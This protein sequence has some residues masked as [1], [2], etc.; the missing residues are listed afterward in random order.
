MKVVAL[1]GGVGGAKLADGLA[2]CLAPQELTLVVNTGDDFLHFGLKI[3]PDLDTVCYT[4]AGLAN[5]ETGWGRAG[6]TW[7]TLRALEALGAPT[8]FQLGDQ[9]LATHLE[10]TRR[11]AEGETLSEVTRFFCQQWGIRHRVLPMSDQPVRTIV[12]TDIGDLPF[13]EYFV[14]YRFEPSVR[15]FRFE[16]IAQATAAPGVLE[17]LAD[18]DVVIFCPSNPWVSIDPILAVPGVREALLR[19]RVVAVSPIVGG[20][21]LKGP[22]AK[23]FAEIGI[24]PSA[25]A[26]ALHYGSLLKGFVYDRADVAE[27]PAVRSLGLRTL[28]TDTVMR[29]PADRR[30][31]AEEILDFARRELIP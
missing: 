17:A 13:Q 15:G 1:A 6:E 10:R 22:A 7:N 26:V 16:G 4:L 31:L 9:D 27:E 21:A 12:E 2:R 3:C 23:M 20:R 14:K 25:Q 11:L 5:P 30:R 19:A 8:W 29:S 28:V 18:C 24:P